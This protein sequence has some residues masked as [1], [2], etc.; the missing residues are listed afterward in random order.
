[1][2]AKL[3]P[4][5]KAFAAAIVAGAAMFLKSDA[6]DIITSAEW[7]EILFATLSGG[8]LTWLIPN[9]PA[10]KPSAPESAQRLRNQL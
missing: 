1:M 7:I 2:F 8:G 5:R 4:Y 6:D 3:K 9:A 10:P